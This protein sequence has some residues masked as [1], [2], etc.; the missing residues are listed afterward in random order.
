MRKIPSILFIV[1]V[2][3]P[4]AFAQMVGPAPGG[5]GDFDNGLEKLFGGNPVF[6]ATMFTSISGPSGPMTVKSKYVFDHENSW[7]EM[8]MA[9]VQSSNL[10]PQALEAAAQM[11]SIGMDE[12]V[13]ITTSDKKNAYMIYPH[14]HSYVA[15]AIPP[16]GQAGEFKLQ[17]T[18]VGEETVDGHPC[19]K[20]DVL[21]TNAVQS[22]DFTVWNATDLNNFPL[23]IAMT[24]QGMPVTITFE[25]VSFNKPAP[26]LFA[27]PVHFTKYGSIGDLMQSAEMNHPGGMPG[28]PSPSVSPG[29]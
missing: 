13:S 1:A 12:V 26:G 3:G 8:N 27:P 16:Q 25:N 24:E 14:I 17:R 11:K 5:G 22:N 9:D 20:N 7:T 23:K 21:I 28:T 4:C 29:P 10:P 19:I 15:I 6:S 2:F 18:K